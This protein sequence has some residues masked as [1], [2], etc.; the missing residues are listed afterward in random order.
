M[1][2]VMLITLAAS[3]ILALR[4]CMTSEVMDMGSHVAHLLTQWMHLPGHGVS[5]S[6]LNSVKLIGDV[7]VV[8]RDVIRGQTVTGLP[9]P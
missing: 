5:P 3:Q 8:L 9:K 6:V 4:E 7:S 2:S 1:A